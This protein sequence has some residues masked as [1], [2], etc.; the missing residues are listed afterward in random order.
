MIELDIVEFTLFDLPPLSEYELYVKKFGSD[1]SRQMAIQ[2]GEDNLDQDIQTDP[3]SKSNVWV[4]WPPTDFKGYGREDDGDS[5]D[6][7]GGARGGLKRTL[8]NWHFSEETLTGEIFSH[9]HSLAA[10]TLTPSYPGTWDL[11]WPVSHIALYS[12][13]DKFFLLFLHYTVNQ[14]FS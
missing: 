9:P 10:D 4:Q 13:L 12:G 5:G 7:K 3:I 1:T 11:R 8:F 14:T 2:T 6:S